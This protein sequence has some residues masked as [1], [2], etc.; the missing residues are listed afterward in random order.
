VRVSRNVPIG[1]W[2]SAMPPVLASGE[3]PAIDTE[4][5]R[6]LTAADADGSDCAFAEGPVGLPPHAAAEVMTR[7]LAALVQHAQNSRRVGPGISSSLITLSPLQVRLL[8]GRPPI[9][10]PSKKR[11]RNLLRSIAYI[12]I[13]YLCLRPPVCRQGR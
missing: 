10:F 13:V 4:T 3:F 11:D 2:A 1:V 7:R 6:P 8:R 5:E 12:G 9:G